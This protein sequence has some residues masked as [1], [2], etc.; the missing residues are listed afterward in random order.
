[1]ASAAAAANL[2]EH[3]LHRGP[4]GAMMS[5]KVLKTMSVM[6]G[7]AITPAKMP[8]M[9]LERERVAR[10]KVLM[11]L[12]MKLWMGMELPLDLLPTTQKEA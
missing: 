7:K 4:L 9:I 8:L 1:M 12:Q 3:R 11:L 6:T 2:H 10:L 5:M